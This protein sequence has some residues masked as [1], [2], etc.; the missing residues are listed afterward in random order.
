MEKN[1][2]V[3]LLRR[4]EILE[5]KVLILQ[6]GY[7]PGSDSAYDLEEHGG[8]KRPKRQKGSLR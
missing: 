5:K 4:I 1:N 8:F 6:F 3:E 2:T 7:D